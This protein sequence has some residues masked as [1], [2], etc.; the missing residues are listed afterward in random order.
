M[1]KGFSGG[2]F[3]GAVRYT[4][5]ADSLAEFCCHCRD[6]Q[7][8]HGG[9]YGGGIATL[10]DQV[11]L[12]GELKRFPMLADSGNHKYHLSCA[13]CGFSIGEEIDEMNNVLMLSASTLDEPAL[14]KPTA[15]FWVSSKPDWVA[16]PSDI[17][18]Y[19]FQTE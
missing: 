3:C 15:H 13:Q 14:F 7:R 6:C 9:A 18:H 5:Q 4:S 19:Q 8:K 10:K 2:C 16:L 11:T 1:N 12:T 17:P